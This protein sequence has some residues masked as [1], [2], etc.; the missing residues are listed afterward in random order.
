M[1]AAQTELGCL[2][3]LMLLSSALQGGLDALQAT[4]GGIEAPSLPNRARRGGTTGSGP[5][6][7]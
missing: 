7:A 2:T 4:H 6:A 5:P 3:D 1:D